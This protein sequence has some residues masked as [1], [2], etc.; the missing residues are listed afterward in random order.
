MWFETNFFKS[1][2]MS[3]TFLDVC[4]FDAVTGLMLVGVVIILNISLVVTMPMG[5]CCSLVMIILPMPRSRMRFNA[6]FTVL[7]RVKVKDAL[8]LILDRAD[9]FGAI[10]N[11]I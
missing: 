11:G 7:S 10:R 1:L 2:T 6:S 4:L 9:L 8:N 3:F 5:S